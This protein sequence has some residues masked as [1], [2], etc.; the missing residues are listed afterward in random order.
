MNGSNAWG[1]GVQSTF[2]TTQ[3][4]TNWQPPS[5]DT[6]TPYSVNTASSPP[7]INYPTIYWA[8]HAYAQW[9]SEE[10]TALMF[11]NVNPANSASRSL[12]HEPTLLIRA[13]SSANNSPD[14][15]MGLRLGSK[16]HLLTTN[17]AWTS[18]I[19]EVSGQ[20]Y[21]GELLGTFPLRWTAAANKG[22]NP[23]DPN[24]YYVYTNDLVE[25]LPP[26]QAATWRLEY[27]PPGLVD[28]PGNWIPYQEKMVNGSSTDLLSV[29]AKPQNGTGTA[30]FLL[31]PNDATASNGSGS[32]LFYGNSILAAYRA[33]AATTATESA[34]D[35][36]AD[37][38]SAPSDMYP[39]PK[40]LNGI[41]SVSN[42]GTL[43]AGSM[44]PTTSPPPTLMMETVRPNGTAGAGT[45][46]SGIP[47]WHR[48]GTY[49]SGNGPFP[50]IIPQNLYTTPSGGTGFYC[51]DA[52]YVTRR[53]SGGNN[54]TDAPTATTV[55]LPLATATS[56]YNSGTLSTDSTT[57][58]S[59]RPLMLH[60][61][62][63]TVAELG[64][65]FSDTPWKNL[66]FSNPESGDTALLDLF[67]IN[68][69]TTPNALASGK[70]DLNTRQPAVLQ[71]L[72]NGAYRDET[73]A[74]AALSST[75]AA[76][77]AQTLV[78]RDDQ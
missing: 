45:H 58:V 54:S 20:A 43:V 24:S 55:G 68:E 71:A 12:Y 4:P 63:R 21:F 70:V 49:P 32:S 15:Y 9:L 1:Y 13:T 25:L 2:D 73:G 7:T 48:D 57:N 10:S 69:D 11:N 78:T 39:T 27:L 18:G 61:P 31:T 52:D 37:R 22:G 51:Y 74:V 41:Y 46:S 56:N 19:P 28:S 34:W 14:N 5:G 60:R 72:L 75:E 36:R 42:T 59:N 38:W 16:H 8:P 62:Y 6:Y 64:Y 67:C 26:S 66:D 77:L 44:S 40:F 76:T 50:G 53:G 33:N 17:P 29:P 3:E 30:P 23:P 35:P 47:G 65:V